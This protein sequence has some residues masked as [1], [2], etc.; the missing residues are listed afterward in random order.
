MRTLFANR[1]TSPLVLTMFLSVAGTEMAQAANAANTAAAI[2]GCS[3]QSPAH[4]VALLELYTSEGCSSCPPADRYLSTVAASAVPG[5]DKLVPLS[6]HVDYWNNIGWK[7]RFSSRLYT[8]RQQQ[9]SALASSRTVY[10]PEVFIAGRELRDW[11]NGLAE[12]VAKVNAQPAKADLKLTLGAAS[13]KQLPVT[14]HASAA[15]ASDARLV[16]ALY[17]NKLRTDVHAGENS[18][19]VLHHYRVVRDWLE[20]VALQAGLLSTTLTIPSDAVVANLGVVAFVQD[21]RGNVLQALSL[22]GCTVR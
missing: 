2:A 20:P 17:E 8:E 18:G 9:L 1:L 4:T 11:Q 19:A 6:L 7:D 5:P 3:R 12:R 13:N 22:D 14:V 15:N 10:T 21:S 16:V